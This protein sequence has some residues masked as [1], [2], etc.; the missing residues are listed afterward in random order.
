MPLELGRRLIVLSLLPI[1]T[2]FSMFYEGKFYVVAV[3]LSA[4]GFEPLWDFFSELPINCGAAFVVVQHLN[5]EYQSVAD[6]LLAKHTSM[7]V[8]WATNKQQVKPNCIYML[9]INKMMT[10]EDG[11]LQ[12]QDRRVE[13][14]ANWAV[15]IFFRSLA[16]GEKAGAIGIVLSG[17]GSDGALGAIRIHDEGGIVMV[18]DPETAEF[19]SMPNSAILK[20]HP[21]EILSP[22]LLANALIEFMASNILPI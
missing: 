15:D 12:L 4:G 13:D 20:D 19:T 3:G 10:I 22:K 18:Q 2:R 11:Y 21:Q 5:R 7:P 1:E 14:I 8:K 17:A 9:P 6:K 16:K